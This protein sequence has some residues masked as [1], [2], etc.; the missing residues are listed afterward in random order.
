MSVYRYYS[1]EDGLCQT[2]GHFSLNLR[3]GCLNAIDELLALTPGNTVGWVGC[4]DGRELLSIATRYPDV[5]FFGYEINDAALNIAKRV[6]KTVQLSN[7]T[8]YHCDFTT[9]S[10][11]YTH[12][13][14]TALSGPKLYDHL[15]HACTHRLCMLDKMWTDKNLLFDRQSV[16]ISGSG[17]RRRLL[18]TYF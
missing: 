12:I 5:S 6:L 16:R 13:Y 8:L 2:N 4:G 10:D 7:V 3:E 1:R 14:S 17:E 15:R 18:A 11:I 9:K